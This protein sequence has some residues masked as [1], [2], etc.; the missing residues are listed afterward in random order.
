MPETK[1]FDM[2]L[3]FGISV[4]VNKVDYK[5]FKL[6]LCCF[7]ALLSKVTN[8]LKFPNNPKLEKMLPP[9]HVTAKQNK[10]E[11]LKKDRQVYLEQMSAREKK[12]SSISVN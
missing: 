7:R 10:T 1:A 2:L 6:Y 8:L 12:Q 11:K 4:V 9:L 5:K 3:Q